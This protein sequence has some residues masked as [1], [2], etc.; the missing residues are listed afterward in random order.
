MSCLSDLS[1]G[2]PSGDTLSYTWDGT[3]PEGCLW[4]QAAS[5][6]VRRRTAPRAG[7]RA[8][9]GLEGTELRA[10]RA[11][12]LWLAPAAFQEHGKS[13][14]RPNAARS[15]TAEQHRRHLAGLLW[16]LRLC[17]LWHC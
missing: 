8:R 17:A 15:S 2:W 4:P 9:Q 11:Q 16:P 7:A 12:K 13:R 3:Q 10:T 6:G 1:L 5:T 14:Q